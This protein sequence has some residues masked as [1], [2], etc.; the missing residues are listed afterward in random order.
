MEHVAGGQGEIRSSQCMTPRYS[1][2]GQWQLP[3]LHVSSAPLLPSACP[4]PVPHM[5]PT[6][7][8]RA[9]HKPLTCPSHA[10]HMGLLCPRPAVLVPCAWGAAIMHSLSAAPP[11]MRKLQINV[12]VHENGWKALCGCKAPRLRST[13]AADSSYPVPLTLCPAPLA[14]LRQ[15]CSSSPL[16]GRLHRGKYCWPMSHAR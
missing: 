14:L 2:A 8:P 6:C 3:A 12:A 4:S 7:S 13:I 5:P 16:S 11:C 1:V 15:D 9:C 10:P